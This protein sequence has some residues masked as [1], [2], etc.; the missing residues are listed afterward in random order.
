M[1]ALGPSSELGGCRALLGPEQWVSRP[2]LLPPT[3]PPDLPSPEQLLHLA[4]ETIYIMHRCESNNGWG[5]RVPGAGS[6]GGKVSAPTPPPPP[7]E[8]GPE[9]AGKQ[10][11]LSAWL[12]PKGAR[13]HQVSPGNGATSE[14]RPMR[15]KFPKHPSFEHKSTQLC[16][17]RPQ[18]RWA[19]A[20]TQSLP[21]EA[22]LWK[23]GS[24]SWEAGE[25]VCSCPGGGNV[26]TQRQRW[27]GEN[28]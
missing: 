21:E 28:T 22:V 15:R 14:H 23:A 17:S 27:K 4:T 16:S 19:P 12:L 1:Q 5:S 2:S 18:A 20:C 7:M 24:S 3:K 11:P 13:K 10:V 9:A 8:W 25:P 26:Q 6:L